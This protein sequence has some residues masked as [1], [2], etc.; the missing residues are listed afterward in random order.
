MAAARPVQLGA[1]LLRRD[2]AG[3]RPHRPVGRRRG[4]KRGQAVLRRALPAL[5]PGRELP[6]CPGRPARRRRAADA[7]QRG[8]AVGGDAR[9]HEARRGDHPGHDAAHHGRPAGPLRA[10]R[11]APR[12]R[13]HGGH[14]QVRRAPRRLRPHRGRRRPRGLDEPRERPRR[15]RRSSPRTARRTRAIRCCS[16][17]PRAPPRSRSWSRT[18]TRAIRSVISRRCTGSGCMPGDVH[19]NISSPGLGQA[20]LEQLLRAVER[21]RHGVRLQLRALQ[22]EGDA[23]RHHPLRRDHPVRPAHRVAHADPGGPRGVSR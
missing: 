4:R 17:S 11:S 13:R 6:P 14:R 23:R 21:R 16:T 15:A 5:E 7:R 12:H 1:R 2:G 18:P 19:F 9:L 3:Q 10:R 8:A 20:R 22:R